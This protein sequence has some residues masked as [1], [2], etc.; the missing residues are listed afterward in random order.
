MP[1]LRADQLETHLERGLA[2]VYVIHGDEPLLSIEAGDSIRARARKAGF[3]ERKV[4]I[5]ERGFKW[6]EL[7]AASASMSLFGDKTLIEMRIPSG[8]PGTEGAEDGTGPEGDAPARKRRR[9]RGPRKS[10]KVSS[11]SEAQST[12]GADGGQPEPEKR[13]AQPEE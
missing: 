12:D 13:R 8:K 9:R 1:N 11:R 10:D 3:T 5:A 2:P 6:D 4:L 7:T